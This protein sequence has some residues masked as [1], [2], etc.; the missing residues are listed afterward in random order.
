[1]LIEYGDR[2]ADLGQGFGRSVSDD[3]DFVKRIRGICG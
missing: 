1:L 2:V 3:N